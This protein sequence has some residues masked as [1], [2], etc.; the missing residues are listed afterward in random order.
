MQWIVKT[1]NHLK[2]TS[3]TY[4]LTSCSTRRRTYSLEVTNHAH[5]FSSKETIT[6]RGAKDVYFL[7]NEGSDWSRAK[8]LFG[9]SM[10]NS[11]PL[12]QDFV[13]RFNKAQR[14][15]SVIRSYVIVVYDQRKLSLHMAMLQNGTLHSGEV[16]FI[17]FDNITVPFKERGETIFKK[18]SV[19]C[20]CSRRLL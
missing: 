7:W 16:D 13:K 8:I 9:L 14:S 11:F 18:S 20:L 5:F 4:K 3:N 6:Q 1:Y 17:F 15:S 10:L 12:Y 2:W 19:T